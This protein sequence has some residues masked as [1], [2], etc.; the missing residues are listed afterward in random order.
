MGELVKMV[1]FPVFVSSRDSGEMKKY[2]D[3]EFRTALERFASLVLLDFAHELMAATSPEIMYEMVAKA[4]SE[5]QERIGWFARL[6]KR[7]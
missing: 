1:E 5:A 2:Q 7:F 6:R 4:V 3:I